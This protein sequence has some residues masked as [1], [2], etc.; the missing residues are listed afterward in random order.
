MSSFSTQAQ[1]E[2]TI[3]D[4]MAKMPTEP[5]VRVERTEVPVEVTRIVKE[6]VA[7]LVETVRYVDRHVEVQVEKIIRQ[8]VPVEIQVP[9][10]TTIVEKPVITEVI[11][12]VSFPSACHLLFVRFAGCGCRHQ[13]PLA[14]PYLAGLRRP[15]SA[16]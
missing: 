1:L 9:G 8:E 13:H 2:R 16:S 7:K 12:L 14:D 6:E 10:K 15:G 3:Y 11:A 4:T 5:I